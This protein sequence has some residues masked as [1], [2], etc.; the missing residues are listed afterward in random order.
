M[1]TYRIF[2]D[3]KIVKTFTGQ[4]S[5]F[6]TF[7]W[8]IRNQ[9]QSTDYALKYG[10]YKVEVRDEKT[11]I[12]TDYRT[13][14]IIAGFETG[15]RDHA[16]NELVLFTDNTRELTELRD[17]INRS[18]AHKDSRRA[19]KIAAFLPL[20]NQARVMYCKEFPNSCSHVQGLT[21]DQRADF[22]GLYASE[23]DQWLKE[24][25]QLRSI[26]VTYNTGHVVETNMA[27]NLSDSDMLEYF[28]IGRQFNIGS[29]P[30]DLMATVVAAE[31]TG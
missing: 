23:V 21:E 15:A 22:M 17:N 4:T 11:G 28:S 24:N 2:Q 5:D 8:L 9:G 14:K 1:Y 27:A 10:G 16:I 26:K 31:I 20:L 29:G 19:D 3:N 30:D 12:T 7:K 13:G 18:F 6:E 25:P